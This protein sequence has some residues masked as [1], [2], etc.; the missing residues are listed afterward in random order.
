MCDFSQ[1]HM[2][3]FSHHSSHTINLNLNLPISTSRLRIRSRKQRKVNP[4][5]W[6]GNPNHTQN[7]KQNFLQTKPHKSSPQAKRTQK[8]IKYQHSKSKP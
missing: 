2:K 3:H 7:P 8:T 4:K 1:A 6:I 5:S